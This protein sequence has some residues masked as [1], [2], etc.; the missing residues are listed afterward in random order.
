MS[1]E[2]KEEKKELTQEEQLFELRKLSQMKHKTLTNL[3][4]IHL[5]SFSAMMVKSNRVSYT[6]KLQAAQALKEAILFGLDYGLGITNP[7]IRQSGTL[8]KEVNN[9][10]GVFVQT[11]DNRMLLVADKLNE[12]EKKEQTKTEG[13]TNEQVG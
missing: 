8:A 4:G 5:D 6:E 13:E 3:L 2:N 11:L 9:L 1:E 7:K 10:A 12:Q